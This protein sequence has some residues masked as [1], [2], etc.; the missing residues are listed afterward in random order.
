MG[1]LKELVRNL[2][3][4]VYRKKL[5]RHL[6][7]SGKNLGRNWEKKLGRNLGEL[8]QNSLNLERT[9][10]D[11]RTR[12]NLGRY[13]KKLVSIWRRF[14]NELK[15]TKRLIRYLGNFGETLARNL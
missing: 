12:R 7:R 1:S 3:E 5:G 13:L 10:P 2:C 11:K 4:G 14:W 8:K 15:Q 6:N 9:E